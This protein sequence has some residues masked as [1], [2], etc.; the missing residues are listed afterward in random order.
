MKKI[1]IAVAIILGVVILATVGALKRPAT[2]PVV[3]VVPPITTVA[4]AASPPQSTIQVYF[5]RNGNDA[6]GKLIN[7]YNGAQKTLDIAIYS[8]TYPLIVKA[9]GDTYRRG[10]KVR[11]L[12]DQTG[13]QNGS[14]KVA[15]DDLLTV[16]VPVRINT[17]SG[18]MHLKMSVI[19]GS[20]ATTGSYNYSSAATN[21]NDEMLVVIDDPNFVSKCS[22]EFDRLWNSTGFKDSQL[23][24]TSP[25]TP[26]TPVIVPTPTPPISA[27]STPS[28]GG[29][30]VGSKLSNKYHYLSCRYAKQIQSI[31]M[32]TFSSSSE[33][34][35]KGYSPCSICGPP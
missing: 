30:F 35:S 4:P 20:A 6:S 31:N 19:D 29:S 12:T 16:G 32:V 28:T 26:T 8:L 11:V 9:I 2:Q 7:L 14:Q 23:S 15:I 17:H 13:A 25:P 3:A 34:R 27:I 33:A 18:L 21:E 10:I 1:Y 5:P 22:T 24:Y